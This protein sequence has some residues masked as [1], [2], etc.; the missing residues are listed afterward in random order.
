MMTTI[1]RLWSFLHKMILGLWW[2][3]ST[4][5]ILFLE[6]VC[7]HDQIKMRS[8][9]CSKILYLRWT[10]LIQCAVASTLSVRSRGR[11]QA[12][13]SSYQEVTDVEL[14]YG[15]QTALQR[16]KCIMEVK[17][18]CIKEVKL[19]YSGLALRRSYCITQ[20][21]LHYGQTTIRRSNCILGGQTAFQRSEGFS[22]EFE[23]VQGQIFEGQIILKSGSNK[24][25]DLH[26]H[27]HSTWTLLENI[28]STVPLFKVLRCRITH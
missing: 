2:K 24:F 19:H 4:L 23:D 28:W 13:W 16:S 5:R 9:F 1:N 18:N 26:S 22:S 14:H 6:S 17:Q 7:R 27:M 20:V 15:G 10:D 12:P 21:K 25:Q 11:N 8:F 3:D